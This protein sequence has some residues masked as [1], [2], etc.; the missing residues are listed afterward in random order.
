MPQKT[1][2]NI[3]P[4]YDDFDKNDNFYRVL[5]KPGYPVQARELTTLQSILQNQIE[6]FGSHIFKEGS[7]VIPGGVTYDRYFDS[8]KLNPQHFGID[9]SIYLESIVGKKIRGAESGVTATVQEILLPPELDIEYPTIYVKYINANNDLEPSPFSDGETLILQEAITYGNTTIQVGDSFASCVDNDATATSSAVHVSEG[10]YFIRGTFVQVQKGTIVL[11]PY[12]NSS[13]YRVGFNISEELISSGDDSSLYDNARGFSNYAAPGADRLKISTS[14]SKK[15]LTDFDDKNFV[16]L[17]RI[18]NGEIKKLQDKSTYSIIKDYFAKRT[19][20]ESGDYS[21]GS[22]GVELVESL[23]DRLSND[24]IYTSEQKTEQ[25]NTPSDDLVC[26]KISPGKA[27]VRGYDIDFPGTTILDVEK[28]RDL[29]TVT[30]ASIPFEMGN[31]LKV[32]NVHGCPFVGLNNNNNVVSLQS[33]RKLSDTSPDGE[34]IGQAR[35]YSFSASSEYANDSTAFNLYLFDVQTYTKLTLNEFVFSGYC[36]ATSYI[37]GLSSGASGYLVQAPGPSGT[38]GIYLSQ[39]SGNFIVGEQILINESSEYRRSIIAIESHGVQDIKSVYQSYTTVSGISTDFSADTILDKKSA[40]GFGINDKITV[41]GIGIATCAGK[42][43]SGISTNTIIRYQRPGFTTETY[44]RVQAVSSDLQYLYLAGVSTVFGVCDG[45]VPASGTVETTFSI[46]IPKIENEDNAF[47][48]AKLS[49]SNVSS[50]DLSSSNITIVKQVTSQSTSPSGNLSL[51]TN[52]IGFSSAFFEP[53]D[54]DRYS[55]IYNDGAI[56]TLSSDQVTLSSNN[57]QINF[58]GL[59]AGIGSVT[60]NTTIKRQSV[61][62][63]RKDYIRSAKVIVSSTSSGV[64]TSISGLSTSSYYGLRVEDKEISLNVPDVVKVIAVYESLSTATPTLDTLQFVSGLGLDT[65]SIIGEKIIGSDSGAVAQIVNRASSTDIEFVYLNSN[66]FV[67]GELVK[68]DESNIETTIQAITFGSYLNITDRY[69]LDKG[70]REQYYDYS[71]IVRNRG[72]VSPS[73]KLLIIFDHYTVPSNDTGDFYTVNSYDKERYTKDIPV[74]ANNTRASDIIDFRPRVS[75]F[76]STSSSPFDFSSRTFGSSSVNTNLVVSPNESSLLG[77]KYY[78][79]RIDKVVLDKQANLSIIKGTSSTTPKE[80]LNVEE[81][82]TIATISYPPYLY[83]VKDASINLIDN[84][85]YTMRDIG[86]LEDRI[87]T[88]ETVTSLSLLELN[89]K[90]LQIQDAD[91]LSR[92]KSGFFVDDFSDNGRMDLTNFDSKSDVDTENKELKTPT[93]FYSLKLEPSLSDTVNSDTA[94]FSSNLP[95]LDPNV[96]KTG[97]LITLNYEEKEWIQQPLASRVENVNPFQM[98]EYIG[99]IVLSPASDNWV[100]NVYVP[101]GTRTITGGWN[102]SYIDNVLISSEPDEYMRSR[103]VQFSSGGLKPL[104][105]YYPFLD[106]ISGIDVV[107]KLIEI[108][109]QS[110]AFS[111]GEDVEG[112]VGASKLITFRTARPDHKVGPYLTPTST[113][114]ANPYNTSTSLST[115]YSASSTVLNIDISSLSEEALGKYSGYITIGMVLVGKTSGATCTVSNIRLIADTYGDLIGSFFIRNPLTNP[116]P[117]IRIKTGNRTFKLSTSS[118]NATPLPG[119]LL[120]SSGETTYSASGIVDT[121]RQ[122]TVIVRTPPPPPPN[123]GGGKDPLAQSF[124]VDETGAFLTAVDLYFASKD[125]NEKCYVEVR[126]VELGTPTDRLVQDFAR[127]VL[128]PSDIQTSADASVATKVTFPSPI[129]LQ[130]QKEYAIVVLA[131]TSNNYELWIARMGEKTVNGQNLPDAESVVVTKQYVGGSLFKSQNG[132][133]WTASQF[134][135]L[136]FKLYKAKFTSQSGSAFFYNP[137]LDIEDSNIQKLIPD[138][139][140]IFPRKIDV[141]ITTVSLPSIK[142]LLTPG[143]KVKGSTSLASGYIE[144]VG[145]G[146]SFTGISTI[147]VGSGYS[148]GT[149]PNV[150]FYPITGRGYGLIAQSVSINPSGTIS[151]VI[152]NTIGFSTGQGFSVGD[153]VGIVTSDVG[154]VGSGA[155]FSVSAIEGYDTLY[156]TNVQGDNFLVGGNLQIY[157]NATTQVSY[158]NTFILSS[159][160]VGGKYSGNVVEVTQFN[161][162]MTSNNNKVTIKGVKPNTTPTSL[163]VDL[164]ITDTTISLAN[165]TS[166][167]RFE[168]ITTSFGY[169]KVNN[170]IIYYNSIGSGVLGIA[171][172]GVDGTAIRKHYVNDPVYKYEIGDVSLT[173]VNTTHDMSSDATLRNLNDIDKYHLE[174]DRGSRSSGESQL[175]FA[176]ESQVGGDDISVSQ[177]IQYNSIIPQFNVITP[178][179]SSSV[180]G[181]IRTVSGTSAGGSE[182][183][184]LDNGFESVQLNQ[185]ND[186]SSPR[187]VCSRIN[188]MTRLTTLPKNRSLTVNVSMKSSDPN[189]S[190]AIDT[191]TAFVALGRNRL[192]NPI[193]DYAADSRVNELSGDPHAAIYISQKVNL[194]QPATSLKVFVSAYRDSSADFRVLYRLYKADSSEVSQAYNLFPGYDN[195]KDTNNDG[196][197]DVIIDSSK[198]NGKPDKFVR[199]SRTDEFI[200]YQFS[201]DDLEQFSGYSIKIVMSGTNEAKAPRFKDIR[202]IALA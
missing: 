171:T 55:I 88:L 156:L 13:S 173:R 192:N 104:G 58:S 30:S 64:S 157:T 4:Y 10:V 95:L 61:Q 185:I 9:I 167:S 28:P 129:Y 132:T 59:R 32:N 80:P 161:H 82:M 107:P 69:T 42:T 201:V 140:K 114:N 3:N 141:G 127:V 122:D 12:S 170:E 160:A 52:A 119:S 48:Y 174:I 87:E 74:L 121:Y 51:N 47:L 198:N 24:G 163:S 108:T 41:N 96:R 83:N 123:R 93:D 169:L 200:E 45:G 110:G 70:Q 78:L 124:T 29:E 35:V 202:A 143:K 165:T 117:S 23:N 25:N 54:S 186:L 18:D 7:M 75:Q 188:E 33:Y 176:I 79:P 189:L 130:P 190:P 115:Q 66:K 1:N 159:N 63:K 194:S 76:T 150:N 34:T 197:G 99:R 77:Y 53:Y 175:N 184:F 36:P 20:E 164:D 57:S 8:V 135:D 5:F 191:Q 138:S 153:I 81:A 102:G 196:F 98:I 71:R 43:F 151:Q 62:S 84:R 68:F 181:S 187:L 91:G 126:E 142:N 146:V 50:I 46:G 86:K 139:I 166:F 106:G 131:P 56:E 162:G 158:A 172:R 179:Q 133:I 145:G 136:K 137:K 180:S 147:S 177:N 125:E 6:S 134:E 101:G 109:M 111:V 49:S 67:V 118:T 19:F 40:T 65:K 38:T 182:V 2:L 183:S 21:V 14:L 103:N 44:N 15:V 72:S 120:I 148:G 155:R 100:R 60:V 73:R 149:Y 152:L 199:S 178:G 11:D 128:F 22:F 94:D 37:R 89:T 112:F 26:V 31:L 92:F 97:D 16:E 90:S 39:T 116:S 168:G 105:R 113:Y 27:Y 85:R 144:R 154:N 195:L 17:I 193:T